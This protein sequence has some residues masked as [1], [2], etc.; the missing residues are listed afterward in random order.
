MKSP[1]AV[2][3]AFILTSFAACSAL[4]YLDQERD[5]DRA[6]EAV[7]ASI[8]QLQNGSPADR[9]LAALALGQ[10]GTEARLVIPALIAA[11]KDDDA[12]VRAQAAHA[13]GQLGPDAKDAVPALA[14]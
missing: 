5:G 1:F 11:L 2:W 12:N 7:R 10:A 8:E 6:S 13:L 14:Q 4:L 9:E 3:L